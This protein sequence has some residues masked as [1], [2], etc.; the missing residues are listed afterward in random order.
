MVTEKQRTIYLRELQP[1][2]P[3]KGPEIVNKWT[4]ARPHH[5]GIELQHNDPA[6]DPYSNCTGTVTIHFSEFQKSGTKG[7]WCLTC[8]QPVNVSI[9]HVRLS[10]RL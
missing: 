3:P 6:A 10:L 5:F 7:C 8:K 4:V 9:A 2:E 1:I